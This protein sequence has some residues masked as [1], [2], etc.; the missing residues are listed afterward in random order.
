MTS[1]IKATG[2]TG[3]MLHA[4]ADRHGTMTA[5]RSRFPPSWVFFP[6]RRKGLVELKRVGIGKCR[7]N[8]WHLTD[9]GWDAIG[10][11]PVCED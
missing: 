8:V 5:D 10:R 3:S 6:L 7:Y 11:I 1:K 4:M 9:K 2:V